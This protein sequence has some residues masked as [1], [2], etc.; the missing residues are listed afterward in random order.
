MANLETQVSK[1][2][3]DTRAQRRDPLHWLRSEVDRLLED[4][5]VVA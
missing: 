4:N 5:I 3:V 2:P 1:L